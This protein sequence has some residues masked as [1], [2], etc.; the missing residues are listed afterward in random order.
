LSNESLHFAEFIFGDIK[1]DSDG[2]EVDK[3]VLCTKLNGMEGDLEHANLF[4][5]DEV[6]RDP[7]FKVINSFFN[8]TQLVGTV[9]F[10]E[11]HPQFSNVWQFCTEGDFGISLEY[12]GLEEVIGISGTVVPR[13]ERSK[14]LRA[15][16]K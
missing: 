8:G 5:R 6:S 7:L 3:T 15:Y 1:K 13:N 12:D 2:H 10:Y 9:M 14:V 11:E 16:K 4:R